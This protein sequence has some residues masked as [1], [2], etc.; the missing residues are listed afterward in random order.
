MHANAATKPRTSIGSYRYIG[1]SRS[2]RVVLFFPVIF[3]GHVLT[4]G[5]TFSCLPFLDIDEDPK[6]PGQPTTSLI[7]KMIGTALQPPG[8]G[9]S[10]LLVGQMPTNVYNW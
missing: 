7:A 9:S 8:L 2:P 10:D 6:Q 4:S 1:V 3:A 5:G